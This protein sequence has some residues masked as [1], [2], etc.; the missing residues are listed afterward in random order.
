M[1]REHEIPQLKNILVLQVHTRMSKCK[2]EVFEI[3]KKNA[4][5]EQIMQHIKNDMQIQCGGQVSS[6]WGRSALKSSKHWLVAAYKN[7][8][9]SLRGRTKETIELCGFV[10][11]D[12][13]R[14]GPGDAPHLYINLVC[15][16]TK[17]YGR[18][19]IERVHELACHEKINLVKLSALPSVRGYY[20]KLGYVESDN[21]CVKCKRR[22]KSCKEKG[23]DDDGYR[24]TKC[25]RGSCKKA[26]PFWLK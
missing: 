3:D 9:M 6:R 2:V 11:V 21:A 1:L 5:A 8:S 23:N 19:L 26:I 25:I 4:K 17:G 18:I 16:G 24:M 15:A 20:P 14:L 22:D 7:K 12:K 10:L 13:P